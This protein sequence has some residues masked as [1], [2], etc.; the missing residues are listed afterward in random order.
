MSRTSSLLSVSLASC[1]ATVALT[2]T[3]CGGEETTIP[4]YPVSGQVLRGDKPIFYATVV[5]HP[6]SNIG[7]QSLRPRGVT[8]PDGKFALT[9]FT[10]DDGAPAG[11]YD[12]SVTQWTTDKPE[13]GPINRLAAKYADPATS[14][15]KITVGSSPNEVQAIVIP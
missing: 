4:T 10:A 13:E 11:D 1:V 3:G 8:D 7:D 14:G 6:K 9:T 15:L 12:V 5:L 2:L